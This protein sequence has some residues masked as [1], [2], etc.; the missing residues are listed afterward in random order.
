[1]WIKWSTLNLVSTIV[2]AR[3]AL[4]VARTVLSIPITAFVHLINPNHY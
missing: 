4:V 1:M 2:M 3:I